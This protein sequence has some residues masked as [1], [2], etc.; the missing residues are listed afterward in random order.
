MSEIKITREK[1]VKEISVTI[2]T[3]Y[4]GL[5]EVDFV[6]QEEFYLFGITREGKLLLYEGVESDFFEVD[7]DG[8]IVVERDG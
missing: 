6:D 4:D 3:E 7:E 2:R 1:V 5:G 8:Y